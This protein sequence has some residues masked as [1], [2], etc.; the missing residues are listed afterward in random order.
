MRSVAV[1]SV[2]VIMLHC[3]Q[4]ASAQEE[5]KKAYTLSS[6]TS[7]GTFYGQAEEIVYVSSFFKSATLSELLWDIKPVFYYGLSLDFSRNQP[8]EKWGF[9][10]T[11]SLK[12]G[13]PGK[14]GKMVDRDWMSV[15]NTEL[16]HYSTH[17][18]ITKELFF[19]DA[20]AGVSLPFGKFLLLKTYIAMSYMR[21]SFVGQYGWGKYARE[22]GGADCGKYALINDDP[23][24]ESYAS[25]EK[26]ITYTQRWIIGTPGISLGF[27]FPG[28]FYAELFFN[29]SPLISCEGFDE[30]ITTNA[31]YRDVMRGGLFFEPEVHF[32]YFFDR[33]LEL[34]LDFSWRH[35]NK[36]RGETHVGSLGTAYYVKQGTAGAGLSLFDT[37]LC[38]KIRL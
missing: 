16:T 27:Y 6:S 12:N 21:F 19:F 22:I 34:S 36:T 37:G 10:S 38:L 11:L 26:V 7:F 20:S 1:F 30:H 18:N 33:R 28:R 3:A 17:N 8:M 24:Y 35:I 13:I 29:V 25:Q 23:K 9:F 32:A 14:S 5:P 2:L 4:F 31:Q 15:E